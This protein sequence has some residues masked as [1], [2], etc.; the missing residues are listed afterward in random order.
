MSTRSQDRALVRR[1]Q[2]GDEAAFDEL[3]ADQ[4]PRLFRIVLAR[5][6]H[7][8]DQAEDLVQAAL[9]KALRKLNTY[10]GEAALLTWLTTFCRH[11]ISA[12]YERAARRPEGPARV[13]EAPEIAAALE[14]L[15]DDDPERGALRREVRSLVQATL[16]RLPERYGAV[17]AWKYLEELPVKE[18]AARLEMT[19]VSVQSLL[20]RARAAFR[21]G[22]RGV[23]AA[24]GL[25]LA[26]AP[27]ARSVTP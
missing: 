17:L 22:F 3:F 10:R 13:E 2:A 20:Q 8:G 16:D 11:E 6:G 25:P 12:H 24:A 1:L 5:L 21:D 4:V 26:A 15:E 14:L 27:P 18:I 9:A 23:G 7:D 19:P